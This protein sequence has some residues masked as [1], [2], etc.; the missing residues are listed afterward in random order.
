MAITAE[1]DTRHESLQ[2]LSRLW[3]EVLELRP[4]QRKVLLLNLRDDEGSSALNLLVLTGVASIETI[5]HSLELRPSDLK[6]I[7][8]EL[9]LDDERIALMIGVTRQQVINLRRSAR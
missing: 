6:T 3:T 4:P 1:S 7:W 9:P 8:Q 5:A 2:A